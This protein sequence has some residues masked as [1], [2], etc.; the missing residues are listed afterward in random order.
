[1]MRNFDT[2][3]FYLNK[4]LT[5]YLPGQ[6]GLSANSILSYRDT[7]SLLIVFLK[8]FALSYYFVTYPRWRIRHIIVDGILTEHA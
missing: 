4:Y 8:A 3:G 1:M 6:R 2:F 5:V 7:F